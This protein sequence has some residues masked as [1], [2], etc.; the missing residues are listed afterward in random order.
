M[1]RRRQHHLVPT[2]EFPPNKDHDAE[3]GHH[4]RLAGYGSRRGPQ[5]SGADH[6]GAAAVAG[7]GMAFGGA[8]RLEP[9]REMVVTNNW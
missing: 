4:V 7:Q 9:V 6:G 3:R 1:R 8:D 2:E 5:H